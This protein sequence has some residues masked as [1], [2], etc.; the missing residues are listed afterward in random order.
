M[1][2][3][4]PGV[5]SPDY[6]PI[7]LAP[8]ATSGPEVFPPG[9][10]VRGGSCSFHGLPFAIARSA[11]GAP[12]FVTYGG[13][14]GPDE[15]ERVIP[16]GRSAASVI[17]AHVA[18]ES[19]LSRGA[20]IGEPVAD[21]RF[22]YADGQ[23]VDVPIRER[24]EIGGID[25]SEPAVRPLP[26]AAVADATP[27]LVS[28]R[29]GRWELIGRRQ[30]EIGGARPDPF[31]LWCWQNPR[32]DVALATLTVTPRGQRAVIA[33]ITIGHIDERPFA[34]DPARPVT[35]T[36]LRP[37]DA[38][39]PF[40]LSIEVDRGTA[41]YTF[42]LPL[43]DTG[44]TPA[45]GAP[46]N[47]TSSPAYA[48][49]A[50]IPSATLVVRH[51]T[52]ELARVGWRDLLAKGSIDRGERVRIQLLDAGR[53]WVRTTV[54][55][56]DGRPLPCRIAFRSAEG[57]PFQPH[58][59]P[60]HFNSDLDSWHIDVGGDVRLGQHTYAYIDG[61]CEGWL[62][63]GDVVVEAARGFEHEPLRA[64]VRIEPGQRE[65]TVRLRRW[66]DMNAEG[67]YSGD[68]HVHFLSTQ[69]GHL[70]ARG[71]DLNVVNLLQAQWGHLF[72]ST[73]EFTGEPSVSRDGRTI[74]HA[75]QEN[76]Q[77]FL[78]H[79]I[80]LGLKRPVMPWSSDGPS[81]AELAGPLETTLS[82]WADECHRQG[83]TVVIPHFPDPNGESATLVATGRADGVEMIRHRPFN[84]VEYYR[85]LNAGYRIPLCGGTDKMSGEVPVG[86]YRTYVRIP[87]TEGFS[88]ES[89]MRNLSLGRT[90]LSGGPLVR[91]SVEG[92]DIGDVVEL[93][94]GGGTLEIAAE[95]ES[96]F[97]IHRLEIV[98]GGRVVASTVERDGA[99]TLRLHE[100]LPVD[101]GTWVAA[102]VG[103]LDYME[104]D[105][106][107][108]AWQR[109]V[110]AHTSPVY[111]EVGG[112]GAFE[113]TGIEYLLRLVEGSR[114]YI[115]DIATLHAP[116]TA[117]HRH[118]E[119]DHLAFLDRPFAEADA[120]LRERLRSA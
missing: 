120:A 70:E 16:I 67:W 29:E 27:M 76:R 33:A 32:P 99:R 93:P 69:G 57:I 80:L 62:P 78:G 81:E 86:L 108:D 5:R 88:H 112:A 24:F 53:N 68:T 96:I 83:G 10:Q 75:S 102:R 85:Y 79:L 36:L 65:L 100:R 107:F 41:G 20:M 58:G 118:G 91:L 82:H 2:S 98:L 89:W 35:V 77:H 95:A 110:F 18:L 43:P 103:G 22:A 97:P 52:E 71:E 26:F 109:G 44:R 37:P 116:G 28:R 7:D 25:P 66:R 74:V 106:H 6:E 51:G 8:H 87:R 49:A 54:L 119:A 21:Y 101:R 63:R 1:P 38:E 34:R 31:V 17:V 19:A 72:T 92:R 113:R 3:T 42:P 104:P 114:S 13:R 47:M 12:R 55:G 30:S 4:D 59:H 15:R 117:T 45:W 105:R 115:R 48:R 39:R 90:F 9:V 40:D 23:I 61:T 50:A 14:A 46:R 111:V 60:D 94:A 84:H 64:R 56:D 11:D 73:E